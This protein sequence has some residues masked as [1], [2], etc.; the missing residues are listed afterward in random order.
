MAAN[1][2][3]EAGAIVLDQTTATSTAT[4]FG[5]DTAT[6]YYWR[7]RVEN[8]CGQSNFS[9]VFAFQTGQ[10]ECDFAFSS[11]DVPVDI[12]DTSASVVVSG[13]DVPDDRFVADVRV[14]LQID[15]S[16][17]G[18]I[19]A[20]LIAP[21]GSAAVLFDQPGYPALSS[22][23]NGENLELQFDDAATLTAADLES[24]CDDMPAISG[25]FQP[26]ESLSRFKNANA[27]GGW[28]L[29][30]TDNFPEDGGMITDWGLTF[31]FLKAVPPVEVLVNNP[32]TLASG[33]TKNLGL[34]N[35]VLSI[36]SGNAT[37]GVFTLLSLPEHGDLLLNGAPLGIGGTFTQADILADA[38]A[39]TNNNDGATADAFLFDALDAGTG[40]WMHAQTF[41]I[42]VVQ[43]DLIATADITQPLLCRD[44]ATAQITATI[45]GGTP[46]LTYS[47]N[48]GTAQFSNVFDNLPAGIYSVVVTDDFGFTAET[49]PVVVDNP[50][51][52]VPTATTANDDISVLAT[53]GTPPYEYSLDGAI[54]QPEPLFENLPNGDYTVTV[55]DANGC[56]GTAMATVYVG[57]LL[58]Q[59][60]STS[61]VSCHGAAD[62]ALEVTVGGGVA[63][64]QYSLDGVDFQDSALFAGLPAGQYT[65]TVLDDSGNTTTETATV[66]QPPVI[67]LDVVVNLNTI[68]AGGMG[69]TGVLEYSLDGQNFQADNTFGGL[70]NG[71]YTVTVRDA[72]GCL[73][74][75]TAMVAVPPLV[76][77]GLTIAG[78]IRCAG[79][80]VSVLVSA[81]GGVPPYIF[82]LDG[83]AYQTDSLFEHVGGGAHAIS[84]R[85]AAG[86]VLSTQP[87]VF[88]E[89]DPISASAAVLG[90]G[91]TITATGGTPPYQYGIGG[92]VPQDNGVFPDLD[93]GAY[94]VTVTD[95]NGCTGVVAFEVNYIPLSVGV[96]GTNPDCAGGFDGSLLLEIFGGTAP[97]DCSLNNGPCVLSDLPAGIY[98][99]VI[100]DGLGATVETTMVLTDPPAL[101]IT[102]TATD[103]IITATASGGTGALEYSLDGGNYQTSPVFLDLPNGAYS[104]F[105]QDANGCIAESEM[106]LVDYVGTVSLERAWG[107]V[108]QPNPGAGHFLL[109]L[110]HAPAGAL[111]TDV[112]DA[113]GRLLFQQKHE[114][115]GPQFSTTLD[116]TGLPSGVYNLR[117]VSG[118]DVGAVRLV[119]K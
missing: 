72:N 75:V 87:F 105:V 47:L 83:G 13:L 14:S 68:T 25:V 57:P 12:S 2:S 96:T 116:L 63:P 31:C 43:N 104:V 78:E 110:R 54:F 97:Y 93:N 30:V 28:K 22:G 11:T 53:G 67:E 40:G 95:A 33:S 115:N 80:T 41:D 76:I 23:C 112:F 70:A 99:I 98:T 4:V 26:I 118:R 88:T 48:G 89:P 36:F 39:Y 107:L 79:E 103:N 91:V 71:D 61:A 1:P 20:R 51:A 21:D 60:I 52:I 10:P 109:T 9:P 69:G 64:Y 65:V 29:E 94:A 77:I 108:V 45:T 18:D 32:L 84:V 73:A 111:R 101:Q 7:V 56:T 16:W 86:T 34:G 82:S 59:Q 44:A 114:S 102:A 38:V 81:G 90:Q 66:S 58:V 55:R 17:V 15:H 113:G 119:V 62:G 106:V 92:G 46:P 117:I 19:V 74:K 24:T 85:D 5:L 49:N 3:F 37:D 50:A 35:L 27:K 100:T 6:V 42:I 8:A